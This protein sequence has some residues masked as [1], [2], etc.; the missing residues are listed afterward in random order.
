M[1][2]FPSNDVDDNGI[3]HQIRMHHY[4]EFYRY[5]DATC[6]STFNSDYYHWGTA[7]VLLNY[8]VS[9]SPGSNNWCSGNVKFSNFTIYF[10]QHQVYITH[11]SLRSRG[12]DTDNM[13]STWRVDGS[14][15]NI[16]WK[17]IDDQFDST[18]LL[19]ANQTHNFQVK[20]PGKYRYFRFTQTD[21]NSRQ[22]NHF[23]MGKVD[24]FGITYD[25]T[26][27]CLCNTL[28]NIHIKLFISIYILLN[29]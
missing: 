28:N 25:N 13:P 1:K 14:N 8:D 21:V 18:F 29:K 7:K 3:I 23:C 22:K 27:T 10:Y 24:F 9:Y 16:T 11:Y 19:Q 20:S 5:V 6:S 26:S 15:D 4:Y 2:T 12:V 17:Y